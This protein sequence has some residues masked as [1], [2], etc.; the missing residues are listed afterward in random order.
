MRD[1]AR[2]T[3]YWVSF[4]AFLLPYSLLLLAH[5]T[6][7]AQDGLHEACQLAIFDKDHAND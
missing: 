3:L 7:V 5:G 2:K 4:A 1:K 6:I